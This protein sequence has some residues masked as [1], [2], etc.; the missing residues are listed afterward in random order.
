MMWWNWLRTP[1]VSLM[2]A[3]HEIAM[4]CRV[5]PK[6]D[7]TCFDHLNGVSNAHAQ[8]TAMWGAVSGP[9]QALYNLSCSATGMSS[10]PL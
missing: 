6:C 5:P 8:P 10:T 7:A 9:P 2:R 1:P 4:P 3:G